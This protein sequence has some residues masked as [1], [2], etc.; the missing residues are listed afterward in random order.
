VD[1]YRWKKRRRSPT[2]YPAKVLGMPQKVTGGERYQGQD[3]P[4]YRRRAQRFNVPALARRAGFRQ[5]TLARIPDV[6]TSQAFLLQAACGRFHHQSPDS[7]CRS[8]E[9]PSTKACNIRSP[10]PASFNSTGSQADMRSMGPWARRK[11]KIT[12]SGIPAA[13]SLCASSLVTSAATEVAT[14][15]STRMWRSRCVRVAS[16]SDPAPSE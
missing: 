9:L 2:N 7:D 5:S 6:G 15:G 14:R 16:C 8:L 11:L 12:L 1:L 10:A 4:R 3:Q 13:T